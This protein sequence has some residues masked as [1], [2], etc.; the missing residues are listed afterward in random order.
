[1]LEV[2]L[3]VLLLGPQG[4]GKGTQ[5][6]KIAAT[7]G[8]PHVATGD[9]LRVAASAGTTLGRR[10]G[11]ILDSG[12]L[13]PDGLMIQL[14][15]ERLCA[16]DT[17]EG[18]VLDGFPRTPPQAE[19]LDAILGETGA[20]F[21]VVIALH[22]NDEVAVQRLL[23]RSGVE[24]RPDDTPEAIQRRLA[25]YHE[26]TEPLIEYY[27]TRGKLAPVDGDCPEGEV[28]AQIQAAL[29]NAQERV[30]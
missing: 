19:A 11:P 1:M 4:A 25:N 6:K 29:E 26:Q 28:F 14:I 2:A 15:R 17:G 13:V 24:G 18:F 8:I 10:V 30:G 22:V 21:S 27:R 12:E 16:E 7:Y 20:N 23:R 3:N 5:A 9:M